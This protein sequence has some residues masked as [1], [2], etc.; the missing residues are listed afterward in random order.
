M[1]MRYKWPQWDSNPRRAPFQG[2]ALPA[3]LQSRERS[4]GV[5]PAPL[6]WKD[7]MPPWTPRT[8][9]ALPGT[10]TQRPPLRGA[11]RCLDAGRSPGLTPGIARP[12][13]LPRSR[14]AGHR[15][16]GQEGLRPR[17]IEAGYESRTQ[18]STL[19]RRAR[20]QADPAKAHIENRTRTS[21]LPRTHAD[22]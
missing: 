7:S 15:V 12:H 21:S 19:T 9:E 6:T 16:R 4:A 22:R 10:R 2:T 1:R 20:P 18:S 3:E 14:S 13:A 17:C 8:L 11:V 5:E